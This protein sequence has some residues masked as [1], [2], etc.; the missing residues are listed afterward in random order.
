MPARLTAE[1]GDGMGKQGDKGDHSVA[2][3]TG[4]AWQI[5]DQGP[6]LDTRNTSPESRGGN[7]FFQRL[8]P[9]QLRDTGRIAIQHRDRRLWSDIT[10]SEASTPCRE[11][12]ITA[13]FAHCQELHGDLALFVGDQY[14]Q[15]DLILTGGQVRFNLRPGQVL[16]LASYA[17][18]GHSH[19]ADTYHGAYFT[20]YRADSCRTDEV[21]VRLSGLSADLRHNAQGATA[22]QAALEI[23]LDRLMGKCAANM[24]HY[25]IVRAPRP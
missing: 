14:S 16:P 19:D 11:H 6:T 9:Q 4:A 22:A 24:L 7:L 1:Q 18:V 15:K 21:E 25:L 3:A 12:H 8:G 20:K 10:R 23:G 13:R 2:H 17:P 5:N